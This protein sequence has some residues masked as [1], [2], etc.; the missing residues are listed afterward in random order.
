M[1]IS[2]PPQ[3]R[4]GW[5]K[6]GVA[7]VYLRFPRTA[8]PSREAIRN[9]NGDS[10][11]E[12][13]RRARRRAVIVHM[14]PI[15]SCALP[16]RHEIHYSA[17]KFEVPDVGSNARSRSL[18][19]GPPRRINGDGRTPVAD[20]RHPVRSPSRPWA[21]PGFVG[22]APLCPRPVAALT[23]E[24]KIL[25]FYGAVTA[26]LMWAIRWQRWQKQ[27]TGPSGCLAA[28]LFV[29]GRPC[30]RG[31]RDKGA[32]PCRSGKCQIGHRSYCSGV[33]RRALWLSMGA[34]ERAPSYS[35]QTAWSR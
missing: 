27:K 8:S 25:D 33:N 20:S 18:P 14:P 5:Q 9:P 11:L 23:R 17:V 3:C 6:G 2:L 16:D 28:A 32:S 26:A 15:V 22:Q 24:A 13:S 7:P 30:L 34:T 31:S 1:N 21:A 10:R 29:R 35:S 19:G 12:E 4:S